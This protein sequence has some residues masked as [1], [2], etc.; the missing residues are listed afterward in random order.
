VALSA[1]IDQAAD[2]YGFLLHEVVAA[3]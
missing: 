2:E 3:Q 1:A